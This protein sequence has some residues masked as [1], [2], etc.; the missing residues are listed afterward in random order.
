M[1]A[2]PAPSCTTKVAA[3]L[4]PSVTTS[5]FSS[6]TCPACKNHASICSRVSPNG[7]QS[8]HVC[9]SRRPDRT[10]SATS[11]NWS[12]T[13]T[14]TAHSEPTT[15][16]RN[17]T[18]TVT[19]DAPRDQPRPR[20]RVQKGPSRA[21]N[22]AAATSGKVTTRT[23]QRHTTRLASAASNAYSHLLHSANPRPGQ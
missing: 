1:I 12:P 20:S 21:A 9:T 23:Y 13:T 16:T 8:S 4:A 18:N 10:L 11:P 7:A 3:D 17:P 19:A 6:T 22:R 5:W 15:T 14:A 2:R